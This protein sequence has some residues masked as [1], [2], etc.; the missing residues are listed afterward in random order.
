MSQEILSGSLGQDNSSQQMERFEQKRDHQDIVMLEGPDAVIRFKQDKPIDRSHLVSN[1]M[2]NGKEKLDEEHGAYKRQRTTPIQDQQYLGQKENNTQQQIK[3]KLVNTS[4]FEEFD[5][6]DEMPVKPAGNRLR[7]KI[8]Q[9]DHT[10]ISASGDDVA[11][12][13]NGK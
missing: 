10:N 9:E 1:K 13:S 6:K 12:E 3:E 5:N 2:I 8:F 11:A 7:K 4:Q